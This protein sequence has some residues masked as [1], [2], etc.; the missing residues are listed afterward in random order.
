MTKS[1]ENT[2]QNTK[3][4][5]KGWWN[6]KGKFNKS[7]TGIGG[8]CVGIIL[9]VVILCLLFPVTALSVE[10]TQVQIDNQTTE[11]TIQG[12]AEPNATVKI[13][14]PLLNLNDANVNV[15]SN[16]SFSYKVSIPITVTDA[17]INITAK[18]PE[19]SQYGVKINIQRPL[20][21]LTINPVD[22]SSDATTLMIQG[23]TDPN[24]VITLNCGD[25]NLKDVQVTADGQG[26]FNKSVTV[27]DNLKTTEIEGTAKVTGKRI[28]TQKISIKRDQPAATTST[29]DNSPT[30]NFS[31]GTS[32][33]YLSGGFTEG[34]KSA[35][36]SEASRLRLDKTGTSI[37]VTEY[38][39]N[40]LYTIESKN[41]VSYKTIAGIEV[42]KIPNTLSVYF[43]KNSKF[44]M[45]TVTKDDAQTPADETSENQQ[46]L[47]DII[48]SIQWFNFL[49]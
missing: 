7:L 37:L 4:R 11:Y 2:N 28:N 26:N 39:S 23:K 13:T 43:E 42:K 24:A 8:C 10:P 12:T 19:K 6:K 33:F 40:D 20:T 44:Y 35:G 36:G 41:A 1:N 46:Y 21:P 18:S 45:I 30:P 48:K 3:G 38:S 29:S 34:F 47:E 32:K 5:L 15:D 17:D 25:L 27:P 22:L 16:G 49:I 31:V 14:A 9:F